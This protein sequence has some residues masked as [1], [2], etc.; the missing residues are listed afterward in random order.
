MMHLPLHLCLPVFL[1]VSLH[2]SDSLKPQYS[3]HKITP[4]NTERKCGVLEVVMSSWSP[5]ISRKQQG[6]MEVNELSQSVLCSTPGVS[7]IPI[8]Q[9][10]VSL[11]LFSCTFQNH[12]PFIQLLS[13]L[14]LSL[15]FSFVAAAFSP[16]PMLSTQTSLLFAL[17]PSPSNLSI[18]LSCLMR[19]CKVNLDRMQLGI[20]V[21]AH[22]SEHYHRALPKLHFTLPKDKG[23]IALSRQFCWSCSKSQQEA[24]DTA[25]LKSTEERSGTVWMG[26]ASLNSSS[27]PLLCDLFKT[28]PVS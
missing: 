1:S 11:L 9:S 27:P 20:C 21:K 24:S 6:M 15:S 13:S 3:H 23:E 14:V 2:Q 18:N 16:P 19:V 25:P 7:L 17:W 26:L 10:L 4:T 12:S 22:L 5:L 8:C 28:S